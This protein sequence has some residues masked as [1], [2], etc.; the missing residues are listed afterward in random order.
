MAV[1]QV[2]PVVGVRGEDNQG[3]QRMEFLVGS[4]SDLSSMPECA[5]GSIAYTADLSLVA[6]FD[7]SSWQIIK[8]GD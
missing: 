7:G 2:N 8:G 1:T 6:M 4:S 5:P 3:L